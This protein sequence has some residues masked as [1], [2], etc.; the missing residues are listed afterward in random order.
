MEL[1]CRLLCLSNSITSDN[2]RISCLDRQLKFEIK[3]DA[4]YEEE[5]L[6]WV[7]WRYGWVE[8]VK[9]WRHKQ[10]L[11]E[12]SGSVSGRPANTNTAEC[13]WNDTCKSTYLTE[14]FVHE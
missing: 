2:C 6:V 12:L 3:K 10:D 8:F 4:F 7:E 5:G 11:P 1:C 13:K 9:A 14:M